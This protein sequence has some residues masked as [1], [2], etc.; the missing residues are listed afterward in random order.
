M[1]LYGGAFTAASVTRAGWHLILQ[2]E[3]KD[4]P[5]LRS[6]R[7]RHQ[8]ELFDLRDDPGAL[9]DVAGSELERA[10]ALRREL[11]EWLAGW[12]GERF[13]AFR[14]TDA[15]AL[16]NLAKLGYASNAPGDGAASAPLIDP[17][18]G[19]AWCGKGR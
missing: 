12:K 13:A 2:L 16:A 19:C 1:A 8:F 3:T 17:R 10:K 5:E 18:C 7:E 9:H 4:E 15:E 14:R 6:H 11:L